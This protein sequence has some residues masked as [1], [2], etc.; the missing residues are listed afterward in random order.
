MKKQE[1][2]LVCSLMTKDGIDGIL[3]YRDFKDLCC[4]TES[5]LKVILKEN[6][7]FKITDRM[8]TFYNEG[9]FL[10]TSHIKNIVGGM[11]DVMYYENG[12]LA[13]FLTKDL[14]IKQIN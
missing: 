6:I 13:S 12:G 9:T 14:D 1:K 7:A 11:G 3:V 2:I 5:K 8:V 10:F 4:I